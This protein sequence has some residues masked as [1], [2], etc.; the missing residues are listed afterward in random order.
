MITLKI[1]IVAPGIPKAATGPSFWIREVSTALCDAGHDVTIVAGDAPASRSGCEPA[2]EM[3]SRAK[4]FLF[5]ARSALEW[6][7]HYYSALKAWLDENAGRL[8]VVDIQGVWSFTAVHAARA[9]IDAA[10]PYVLTPHGQM[11]AWDWRKKYWRKSALFALLLRNVWKTAAAIRFLSDG[12]AFGSKIDPHGRAVVIPSWVDGGVERGAKDGAADVRRKL[13]IPGGASVV[14][15]LG[16]ITAQKGVLEILEAFDRLWHRRRETLLLLVGPMDGA[17]GNQITKKIRELPSGPN[18]RLLGPAYDERKFELLSAASVFITLSKNEGLPIAA[19]EAMRS[20]LPVVLTDRANFPEVAQYGAGEIVPPD[21][22]AVARVL[23]AMLA[24][25]ARLRG[26]SGQA[27][28][29]VE[30]RFTRRAVMPRM[31]DLY[32]R[33]AMGER[34][35][36]GGAVATR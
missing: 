26:M 14:M 30:E 16:R 9:C 25:P 13:M 8:D 10:V 1:G 12:E 28:K 19:L 11:A 31:L 6:R 36:A 17:Y 15:F 35:S 4:L 33:L 23:E 24:N 27:R 18:V 22:E 20:G 7:L 3:D 34:A 5:P 21:P 29:L 2:V 32:S